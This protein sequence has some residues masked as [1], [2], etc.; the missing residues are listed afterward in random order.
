MKEE[1]VVL[2]DEQNNV[3]GTAPKATVHT[4]DTPLHRGFSLFLFNKKGELLLQQ[5]SGTKKTWPLV[6]SN[7]VCGHPM[8]DESAVEAA[9]RRSYFELGIVCDDLY[10]ILPNYRY[11]AER[12]GVVENERCPVVVGFYDGAVKKNDDE[13]EETR[14]VLWRSFM[15]EARGENEYSPWCVEEAL[16]LEKNDRFIE[17]YNAYCADIA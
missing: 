17:H 16:L 12:D 1:Y 10:E 6:W 13:V 9:K 7:S 14:W 5:R 4:G 11:R 8:L 3:T 2:I 15:Q